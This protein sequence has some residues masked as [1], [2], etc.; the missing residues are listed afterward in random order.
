MK[1]ITD[2]DFKN[3]KTILRLD[4]NVPIKDGKILSK[5]K[6][7]SSLK[8]I[9]YIKDHGGKVIILSHLGKIKKE[10][11]KTNNSL[12]VV[13]EELLNIYKENVYFSSATHG[14]VLENKIDNLK[15]GDILLIENTRYEDLPNKKERDRKSVV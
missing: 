11:D 5:D 9:N 1:K 6:I 15:N 2:F 4:L 8:T 10:E 14:R 3:K 7:T 12:Y 13:Y